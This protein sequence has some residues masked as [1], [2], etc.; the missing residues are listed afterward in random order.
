MN[1]KDRYQFLLCLMRED[2]ATDAEKKEF[3]DLCQQM[4]YDI[5]LQNI[6]VLKRLADR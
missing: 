5:M 3:Y 6:D 4:L 1:T 2:V